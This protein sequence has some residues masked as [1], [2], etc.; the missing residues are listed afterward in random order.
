MDYEDEESMISQTLDNMWEN[1]EDYNMCLLILYT[2]NEIL[3]NYRKFEEIINTLNNMFGNN[4]E[5]MINFIK[6]KID[7]KEI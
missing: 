2:K 4:K 3:N 6:E 7:I 1:E 5:E